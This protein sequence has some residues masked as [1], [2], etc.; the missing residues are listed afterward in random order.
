MD[1]LP[2]TG[3][4]A[5]GHSGGFTLDS[6]HATEG[7]LTGRP[8]PWEGFGPPPVYNGLFDGLRTAA[9]SSSSGSPGWSP[10]AGRQLFTSPDGQSP[11]STVFMPQSPQGPTLE[12]WMLQ[13]GLNPER[14]R[15]VAS[16][17]P[18]WSLNKHVYLSLVRFFSLR[19]HLPSYNTTFCIKF[20]V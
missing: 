9:S 18:L 10:A 16:F 14:A 8:A 3:R 4:P 1:L 7:M 17:L 19:K 2:G 15:A 12:S 13:T 11:A 6:T 20:V 5:G